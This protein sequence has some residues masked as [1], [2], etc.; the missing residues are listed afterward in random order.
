MENIRLPEVISGECIKKELRSEVEKYNKICLITG[1]TA[2]EKMENT[3][4]D[5]FKNKDVT[6][7]WYGGEC[8]EENINNCVE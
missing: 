1:K 4:Q 7:V 5:V 6:I 2:L 8:S 3:F